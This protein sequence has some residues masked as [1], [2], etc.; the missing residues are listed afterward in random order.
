MLPK[1]VEGKQKIDVSKRISV[2]VIS[3]EIIEIPDT[4]IGTLRYQIGRKCGVV[5]SMNLA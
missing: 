3:G 4:G 5:G 2:I 1:D